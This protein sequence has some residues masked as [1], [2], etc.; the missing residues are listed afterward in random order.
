MQGAIKLCSAATRHKE[1][2]RTLEREKEE[3]KKK[4]EEEMEGE[5]EKR[6]ARINKKIDCNGCIRSDATI[7]HTRSVKT[8][9]F[10]K[11]TFGQ[12]SAL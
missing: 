11:G 1:A 6:R 9:F 2:K 5:M 12:M 4:K 3:K 7:I 10:S 8:V